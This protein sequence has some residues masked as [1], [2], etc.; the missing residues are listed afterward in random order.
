MAGPGQYS[1]VNRRVEGFYPAIQTLLKTGYFTYILYRD[2][3]LPDLTC[4]TPGTDN[5]HIVLM[6][7]LCQFNNSCVIGDR[8][9]RPCN[10]EGGIAEGRQWRGIENTED[11]EQISCDM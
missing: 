11:T 9:K 7:K 2:S 8:E 5:L 10:Y 6:Q 3:T 4:S 1:S